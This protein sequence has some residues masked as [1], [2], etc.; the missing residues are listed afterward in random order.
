MSTVLS[1]LAVVFTAFCVWL[2][3]SV[4]PPLLSV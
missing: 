1:A 2:T 4:W 3:V